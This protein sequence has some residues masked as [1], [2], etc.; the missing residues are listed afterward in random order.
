MASI[1][2]A[3]LA[4][5][6][7]E[8]AVQLQAIKPFAKRIHIDITDGI[9]APSHTI[10]LAQVY[11]LPGVEIDLHL[12]LQLPSEHIE[13]IISL[14][15]NLVILHQESQDNLLSMIDQLSKVKIKTG[16]GILPQTPVAACKHHLGVVDHALVFTGHLG[17]YGGQMDQSQLSKID[18]IKAIKDLEVSVDGGVNAD[19]ASVAV[20]SGADVLIS[21]GF[22]VQNSDP[23]LAYQQLCELAK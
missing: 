8:F 4:A 7:A 12:M 17:Y 15:P 23:A 14:H 11:G 2:P 13:T 5:T 22:I 16:L 6:P 10:N 1:V 20:S 18:E 19:N 3:I 21:G 9:F